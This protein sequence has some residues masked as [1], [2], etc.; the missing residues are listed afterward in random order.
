MKYATQKER[1]N[2]KLYCLICDELRDFK[3][4]SKEEVYPVRGEKIKIDA[5]VSLCTDCGR[6][7]FNKDLD[8]QNLNLAYSLYRKKHCLLSPEEIRNIREKYSL[9]QRALGRLLEWGEITINRY[10]TGGLQDPSHNEVLLFIKDPKN[11]RQIFDK[12]GYLLTKNIGDSLKRRLEELNKED[13][14]HNVHT[15]IE[16]FLSA[17][18][19]IDEFTGFRKFDLEKTINLILYIVKRSD[20]IFETKL[21]KL[22]W[23]V[24]FLYF[25]LFTVSLTGTIYKHLPY[26]P[27]PDK[28]KFIFASAIEEGL[29]QREVVFSSGKMGIEYYMSEQIDDSC[30]T[31]QEKRIID[32]VADHFKKYN[33]EEITDVSHKEKGYSETA[34]NDLISYDFAS[35]LSLDL[36]LKN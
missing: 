12:N 8:G 13:V 36:K 33:C 30:F 9:S 20:G 5:K 14:K 11:M 35:K 7:L 29:E 6:E 3:I 34:E 18:H 31:K 24:D 28:Y 1:V 26:G 25:K 15:S 27:V 16:I 21:N 32:F 2:M 22:L 17:S 19:S 4:I 10:E 23:Y